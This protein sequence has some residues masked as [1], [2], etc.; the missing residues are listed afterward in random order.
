MEIIRSFKIRRLE[1]SHKR[2]RSDILDIPLLFLAF[3]S[4]MAFPFFNTLIENLWMDTSHH[5]GDLC[6]K[7]TAKASEYPSF[8]FS[9][10]NPA[11]LKAY[12][13]FI[14][15]QR[16]QSILSSCS[17][18]LTTRTS[19]PMCGQFTTED[20]KYPSFVFSVVNYENKLAYV[21]SVYHKGLRGAF[22]GALRG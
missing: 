11:N 1:D 15:P 12:F 19:W 13:E 20:S 22:L 14:L 21:W 4:R 6:G 5:L 7:F 18:W 17:L 3:G 8:V 16:T 9:V 10:V 2:G